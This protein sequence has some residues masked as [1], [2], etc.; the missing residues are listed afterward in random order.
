MPEPSFFDGLTGAEVASILGRLPKRRYPAGATIVLQGD[1]PNTVFVVLSGT[2]DV[3]V[4]DAG[5]PE[6]TVGRVGPGSSFGEMSLLT[7]LTATATVRAAT[8][9][10]VLVISGS[11]FDR[12][13]AESPL[14]YRNLGAILSARLARSNMRV[15][16]RHRERVT[17][18]TADGGPPILGHALACS[19]AWHC[20]RPVL[21]VILDEHL[22]EGE[23][24]AL[25]TSEANLG[26]RFRVEMGFFDGEGLPPRA[27]LVI[28]SP[29]GPFVGEGLPERLRELTRSYQHVLVQVPAGAD[30]ADLNVRRIRLAS[31]SGECP[32]PA[33]ARPGHT[34]AGW[35]QAPGAGRPGPGGVLRVPA[36]DGAERAALATGLLPPTAD[37]SRTLGWAARDIAGLKVGLALGAGSTRGYAHVGALRVLQEAAVP[38]D[39]VAG[40]SV[41]AAIGAAFALGRAP[42]EIADMLDQASDSLFRLTLPTHSFLSSGALRRAIR[43]LAGESAI[44]DLPL[45][46]A[47]VAADIIR[48]R[49]V[50][51]TEGPLWH[52]LLASMSIPGVYPPVPDGPHLLVDG[53]V[54]NPVPASVVSAMGS[55]VTIGVKLIGTTP[56]E[57]RGRSPA[58]LQ[59]LLRSMDMM[60][61]RV[62]HVSAS[63][64]TILIA[65][66]FTQTTV[67]TLR[68][69]RQGRRYI[70]FGEAAAQAA[71]PRIAATL[72]WLEAAGTATARPSEVQPA[73][74]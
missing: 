30:P 24:T 4:A 46:F 21:H 44:E 38:V 59:V 25:A 52:A 20:R 70:E 47:A 19:L 54:L 6:E 74:A 41:G 32:A 50:H 27:T 66:T 14:I 40:T 58:L 23:L 51:L 71:L 31:P 55:D 35:T 56:M 33:G 73:P 60:M 11:D 68:N 16:R 67:L 26:A 65:P 13:V 39:F 36:L 22:P 64:A 18:L 62:D 42:D 2:A 15:V 43:A 49:E 72:P 45:P 1:T 10:E 5:G 34:I 53:G 12:L 7:G 57:T 9:M 37:G 28:A 61:D 69:F 29:R 3:R 8:D 63:A 17:V 48:G